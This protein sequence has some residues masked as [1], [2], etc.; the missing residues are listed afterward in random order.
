MTPH[1]R[2]M[3]PTKHR[4]TGPRSAGRADRPPDARRLRCPSCRWRGLL[5]SRQWCSGV[6]PRIGMGVDASRTRGKAACVS[7][8]NDVER[9]MSWPKQIDA[10]LIHGTPERPVEC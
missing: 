4:K 6:K 3:L 8:L 5:V 7:W 10:D 2:E 1:T 9:L